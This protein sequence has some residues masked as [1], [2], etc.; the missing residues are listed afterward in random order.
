ML[1]ELRGYYDRTGIAAEGFSCE[2]ERSCR[3]VCRDMLTP[4][5]AFVGSQYEAGL[6]PRL[7]FVSLDAANDHPGREASKRTL[8]FMRY[9]EENGL[10]SPA[11][12]QPEN[13]HKG[14]HWYE[15]HLLAYEML[16]PI[17]RDW[18]GHSLPFGT[19]H[20]YFAHTNSAKCKDAARNTSQGHNR[21]FENCRGFVR[22][23]VELLEPDIVITQGKWGRLAIDQSFA[24]VGPDIRHPNHAQYCFQ[25]IEV[26]KRSVLKIST[27]HQSNRRG[28]FH[29]EKANAYEWYCTVAREF[30]TTGA[31]RVTRGRSL[32]PH[33]PK[34]AP[35]IVKRRG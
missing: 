17:A 32:T 31:G 12:C 14:R 21:L 27:F 23:D 28:E 9:W 29:R 6:L 7:L 13:L 34:G 33:E 10:A 5:E 8:A 4:R 20:R 22:E 16:T 30:F 24:A 35:R 18:L 25:F 11:G 19:I 15:T 2:H 26:G 1:N 3:S